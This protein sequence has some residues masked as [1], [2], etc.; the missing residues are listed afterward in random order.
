MGEYRVKSGQ[1]LPSLGGGLPNLPKLSALKGKDGADSKT[2]SASVG[3]LPKLGAGG[4]KLS[5]LPKFTGKLGVAKPDEKDVK[6]EIIEDK[7]EDSADQKAEIAGSPQSDD[8]N[9]SKDEDLAFSIADDSPTEVGSTEDLLA[10]M[11]GIDGWD[12]VSSL[13]NR[14]KI[15]SEPLSAS[16]SDMEAAGSVHDG[17]FD[18]DYDGPTL[19]QS[20]SLLD[21]VEDDDDDLASLTS[22]DKEDSGTA[23]AAK[24]ESKSSIPGIPK[25]APAPPAPKPSVP[26]IPKVAS[27]PKI[28][29]VASVSEMP[30][31]ESVQEMPQIESVPEMP[32]AE[33]VPEIP[34]A[35]SVP[36]M[37]QV[38]SLPEMPKIES[39]PEMPKAESVPEIPKAE[40]VPEMPKTESVPEMPQA[41]QESADSVAPDKSD[42]MQDG[43][44]EMSDEEQLQALLDAMTP[45]ERMAYETHC[46][47]EQANAAQRRMEQDAELRRMYA[48]SASEPQK[49]PLGLIVGII[50]AIIAVGAIIGVVMSKS[51]DPEAD[52]AAAAEEQAAEEAPPAAKRADLKTYKVTV[53]IEGA[54]ELYVNGR[55]VSMGEVDFAEGHMN[56]VMA[57]APHMVPY[58]ETFDADKKVTGPIEGAM[59]S[60][61]LYEKGRIEFRM[62][63]PD[64]A[65]SPAKVKF[66]GQT[67][68]NFPKD[69]I[70]D[71][72]LGRPHILTIET[73]DYAKHMHLIWPDEHDVTVTIPELKNPNDA[74]VATES[75]MKKMP[76]PE[77]AYGVRISTGGRTSMTPIIASVAPG[78]IIEYSISREQRKPL[79]VAVIPDGY[80]SLSL[81]MTLLRASIGE[82]VVGFRRSDK[83]GS[84]YRVCM[85]RSGEVVCPS[86]SADTTVPSGN[87]WVFFAV[88]GSETNPVILQGMQQQLLQNSRKYVFETSLDKKKAFTFRQVEYKS[89][90]KK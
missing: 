61:E 44:A 59:V 3:G 45:E 73:A 25:A 71:V 79:R 6:D 1:S 65:K 29:H 90:K 43:M 85:R 11:N 76:K 17:D 30:Q 9:A 8:N 77:N 24:S 62:S 36:E 19:V 38:E 5:G 67:V 34:K 63:N 7:Q 70:R 15:S 41:M 83:G 4:S 64:Q 66:D 78:D 58:F 46:L 40:S 80:G 72:V 32:Q 88:A 57:F 47:Q 14:D 21:I 13:G 82:S 23:N 10:A 33:S 35:E 74:L 53:N 28:P 39:V 86:M 56:S 48:Q 68:Q 49:S 87:D 84:D 2:H 60:D 22:S 55:R 18:S 52:T 26:G 31:A 75:V 69:I 27:A 12:D 81:D 20:S 37:P 16:L 50:V 42:G 51:G 89:T 54:S